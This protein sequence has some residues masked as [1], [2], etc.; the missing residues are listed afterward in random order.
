[1]RLTVLVAEKADQGQ[2]IQLQLQI[3]PDTSGKS[4]VRL[5]VENWAQWQPD[6]Q[7]DSTDNSIWKG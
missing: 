4:D 7:Y 1:M 2:G 6:I 5:V 3:K